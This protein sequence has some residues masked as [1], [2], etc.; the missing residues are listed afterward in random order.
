MKAR[1]LLRIKNR[2]EQE[3]TKR[4]IINAVL[5]SAAFSLTIIYCLH[6]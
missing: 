5:I 1:D 6:L 3:I 2:R 4:E